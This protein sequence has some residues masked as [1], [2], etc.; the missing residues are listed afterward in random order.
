LWALQEG[1]IRSYA[2]AIPLDNIK[3]SEAAKDFLQVTPQIIA[4][5]RNQYTF[6]VRD[7]HSITLYVNGYNKMFCKMQKGDIVVLLVPPAGRTGKGRAP[8][9]TDKGRACFGVVESDEIAIWSQ[10]KLLAEGFPSPMI[11][12]GLWDGSVWIEKRV[13]LRRI[14]WMREGLVRDLPDQSTGKKKAKHCRWLS[15]SDPTWMANVTEEA[16]ERV[17]TAEFMDCTDVIPRGNIFPD[18]SIASR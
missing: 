5:C 8:G 16:L 1:C 18:F 9:R 13:M 12:E 4:Y 10:D 2:R 3:T 17:S 7:S 14:K 6:F 11:Y 15:A